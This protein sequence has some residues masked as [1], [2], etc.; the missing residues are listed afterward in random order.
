MWLPF[1]RIPL[2]LSLQVFHQISVQ[3]FWYTPTPTSICGGI[4]SH[5]YQQ[6]LAGSLLNSNYC[7]NLPMFSGHLLCQAQTTTGC[8]PADHV[9]VK[10]GKTKPKPKPMQ[11][12]P[13]PPKWGSNQGPKRPGHSY[14][15]PRRSKSSNIEFNK[16]Y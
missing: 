15:R 9:V 1:S 3:G 13:V 12:R 16:E 2:L 5:Y 14:Y 8:K 7:C 4:L 6:C 10:V 11:S